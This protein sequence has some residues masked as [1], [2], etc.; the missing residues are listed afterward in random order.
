MDQEE[1]KE[2]ILLAHKFLQEIRI[3]SKIVSDLNNQKALLKREKLKDSEECDKK[4][5]TVAQLSKDLRKLEIANLQ[6]ENK[7]IESQLR[8]IFNVEKIN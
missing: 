1:N 2:N 3:S 8:K 5:E 4:E 6:A 7:Q